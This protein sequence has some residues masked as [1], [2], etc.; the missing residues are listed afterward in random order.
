MKLANNLTLD[1]ILASIKSSYAQTFSK[2]Q[3]KELI[4]RYTEGVE[5]RAYADPSISDLIMC[6]IRYSLLEFGN[7]ND[8]EE[9]RKRVVKYIKDGYYTGQVTELANGLLSGVDVSLYEDLSLNGLAMSIIRK[10]LRKRRR[11]IAIHA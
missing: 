1:N 6:S 7:P 10:K 9:F 5:I 3:I 11:R 4:E 8:Y 2:Q